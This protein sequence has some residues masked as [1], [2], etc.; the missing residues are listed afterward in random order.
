MG[1]NTKL[2]LWEPA[3]PTCTVYIERGKET[4][5]CSKTARTWHQVRVV[6]RLCTVCSTICRLNNECI[7]CREFSVG[8]AH[9]LTLLN[10]AM[11]FPPKMSNCK[12]PANQPSAFGSWSKVYSERGGQYKFEIMLCLSLVP[13][14]LS[15]LCNLC[16]RPSAIFKIWVK[17]GFCLL[18]T[19][20]DFKQMA[21]IHCF[22]AFRMQKVQVNQLPFIF[23]GNYEL[24]LIYGGGEGG[25]G[26]GAFF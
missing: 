18:K 11:F 5:N 12:Q 6:Y 15:K 25:S 10:F 22:N 20:T 19:G 9:L 16:C 4:L 8:F 7:I 1:E 13:S 23:P 26:G 3:R 2:S 14:K 24:F 21:Q 17:T